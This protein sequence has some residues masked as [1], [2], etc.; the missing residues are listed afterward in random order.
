[1]KYS[2]L[3][4]SNQYVLTKKILNEVALRF[5]RK[6]LMISICQIAIFVALAFLTPYKLFIIGIPCVFLV[7]FAL[8]FVTMHQAK[9]QWDMAVKKH[10]GKDINISVSFYEDKIVY[11][12]SSGDKETSVLLEFSYAHIKHIR[13]SKNLIAFT[14]NKDNVPITI[15]VFRKNVDEEYLLNFIKATKR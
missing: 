1:M 3:K 11:T 15:P 9:T 4:F 13:K 8:F 6:L 12:A 14:M 2:S 5:S 7:N 10:K